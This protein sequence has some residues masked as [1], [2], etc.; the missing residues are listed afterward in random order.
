MTFLYQMDFGDLA[1]VQ[2]GYPFRS[3]LEHDPQGDIAVIQM[4]DIDS[5]FGAL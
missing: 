1:E 2:M 5:A 3:R 4:K